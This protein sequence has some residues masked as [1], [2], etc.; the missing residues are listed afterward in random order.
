MCCPKKK[1]RTKQKTI[2]SP[3]QVKWS[4][5]Q[6]TIWLKFNSVCL[7]DQ[8]I[9]FILESQVPS[10][11]RFS[12]NQKVTIPA[13][14]EMI[15]KANPTKTLP[16]GSN[17]VIDST[18]EALQIKG[19]LVANTLCATN[20]EVL[21][22]RMINVTDQPQIIYKNTFAAMAESIDP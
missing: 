22:L 3:L 18:A 16:V 17:A 10:L 15:I 2:T 7:N 8:T 21:P 1:F 20:A 4:V 6:I 19:L 12:L 11:F 13:F 5:P 14:S 9:G